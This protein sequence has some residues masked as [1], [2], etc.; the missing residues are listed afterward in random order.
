[1]FS[2]KDLGHWIGIDGRQ[3]LVKHDIFPSN[4][5]AYQACGEVWFEGRQQ[6]GMAEP[7]E[8][9]CGCR[10]SGDPRPFAGHHGATV[11]VLAEVPCPSWQNTSAA[12]FPPVWKLEC[13]RCLK[14]TP[15]SSNAIFSMQ[16]S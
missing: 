13:S 9:L 5:G 1:M 2:K 15:A 6:E 16:G 4:L 7:L 3:L 11:S 10:H 14:D 8:P 12:D